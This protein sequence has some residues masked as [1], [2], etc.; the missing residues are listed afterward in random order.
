MLKD[1][2]FTRKEF[3]AVA[4]AKN[5]VDDDMWVAYLLNLGDENLNTVMVSSRGYGEVDGMKKET[6]TL[7]WMLGEIVAQS[8]CVI[9]E[10]PDDVIQLNN[11]FLISFFL[12]NQLL[13]KKIIFLAESCTEEF[14]I[15]LPLLNKKGI[16]IR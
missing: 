7:R 8:I 6:A 2:D 3:V 1:I 11:E 13:D 10:I 9:E 14:M 16:L 5:N 4:L 12:G 15:D